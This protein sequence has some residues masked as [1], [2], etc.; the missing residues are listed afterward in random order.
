M[1]IKSI[2]TETDYQE[3]LKEIGALMMVE[4]NYSYHHYQSFISEASK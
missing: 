4:P 1:E 2:H 3:A